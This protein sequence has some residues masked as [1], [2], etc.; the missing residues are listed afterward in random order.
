[1]VVV[2]E[3]KVKQQQQEIIVVR[4]A[5]SGRTKVKID[6]HGMKEQLVN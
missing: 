1:M 6:I 2:V 5:H 4:G 3:L